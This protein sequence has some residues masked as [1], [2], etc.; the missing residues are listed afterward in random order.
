MDGIV[1]TH[2]K[3]LS[4]FFGRGRWTTGDDCDG[5][6]SYFFFEAKTFFDGEFI[7]GTD[8]PLDLALVD[9]ALLWLSILGLIVLFAPIDETAALLLVPYLAWVS[10]A[11]FLNWTMWRLNPDAVTA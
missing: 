8:D 1:S 10:F 4:Y 6:V 5:R 7:V 9:V 3:G 11:A 2:S